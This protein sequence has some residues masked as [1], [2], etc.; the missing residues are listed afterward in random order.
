MNQYYL[1]CKNL[2]ASETLLDELYT[3]DVTPLKNS[4]ELL[5][6]VVIVDYKDLDDYTT[7]IELE[8][9]EVELLKK[10]NRVIDIIEVKE[11]EYAL[12]FD[13]TKLIQPLSA[14]PT[15]YSSTQGGFFDN[16]GLAFCSN[17]TGF[18]ASEFSYYYTGSGVDI[19]VVDS[20]IT[21][22]HPEFLSKATGQTRVNQIDWTLYY[23]ITSPTTVNVTVGSKTGGGQCFYFNG[24]ERPIW[25]VQSD[26]I[27]NSIF[28]TQIYNFVL[29]GSTTLNYPFF[30][31]SVEGIPFDN[32]I[33]TN[34]GATTGTVTLT[35]FRESVFSFYNFYYYSSASSGM[36]NLIAR[37]L[38]NTQGSLHYTDQNGHGTHCTGTAAGS[39]VGWAKEAQIYSMKIF[40]THAQYTEDAFDLIKQWHLS[41]P[42]YRPTVCTNSW[43]YTMGFSVDNSQQL[44]ID[45]QVKAMAD[46]GIIF[47]H[48]AG[49]NDRLILTPL[50]S[51]YFGSPGGGLSSR[52][53]TFDDRT[54]RFGNLDYVCRPSSPKYPV[55]YYTNIL[56]NP[57]FEVGALGNTTLTEK[58]NIFVRAWYSNFGIGVHI[59]APGSRIQSAYNTTSNASRSFNGISWGYFKN[60][61][62]SMSNPQV[63]GIIATYLEANPYATPLEVKSW[64]LNNSLSGQIINDSRV[65]AYYLANSP[66]LY[67]MQFPIQTLVVNNSSNCLLYNNLC[68]TKVF[69]ATSYRGL[70]NIASGPV[71]EY[72]VCE[73]C[74]A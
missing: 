61:G 74:P 60:N 10:D 52:L 47:T 36:G 38:Y 62:T 42:V 63:A 26:N 25:Y 17:V 50:I 7:I 37:T 55:G 12:D 6:S 51:S 34:N 5:R 49:N 22:G 11:R 45:M 3:K 27:Y 58:E 13:R 1:I 20:G 56:D 72:D 69:T 32:T 19:V 4:D 39:S 24:Q 29:D 68:Y 73:D 48:S 41:K 64:M 44:D 16:W 28:R 14:T 43:G 65:A 54:T 21:V 35:V 18:S 57:T 30:I 33:V 31:G 8:E 46:A 15:F 23:T 71:V 66:N 70:G 2:S 40:N 59:F 67:A 53:N 9:H